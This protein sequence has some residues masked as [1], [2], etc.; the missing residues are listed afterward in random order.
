MMKVIKQRD[1]TEE[2]LHAQGFNQYE[3]KKQ[4]V[5]ARP[6]RRSEAPKRIITSSGEELIAQAGAIICYN[7]GD[8]VRPTL[9]DYDHWP[10]EREIF[11]QTYKA[12]DESDWHPSPPEKHLMGLGCE[13]Y[14]KVAA[15]WA[16]KLD[17]ATYIQS[18][19]HE[20]PELVSGGRYVVIG[21]KG[22]PYSVNNSSFTRRYYQRSRHSIAVFW[23]RI[24]RLFGAT[25]FR[26]EKLMNK[27]HEVMTENPVCC[28]ASDSVGTAARW[29]QTKEIGAVPVVDNYQ[30]KQLIG[31]VTDRD[32]TLR[33]IGAGRDIRNTRIGDVMTPKPVTC[34]P[35]DDLDTALE[36]MARH[37][38][39]RIPVVDHDRQVVGI[40]AQADLATRLHDRRK[41]ADL[42]QE[43][44]QPDS[45]TVRR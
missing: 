12:W 40:I 3:R 8:Q 23:E 24:L 27:C 4:L 16:K 25:A 33:V 32:L 29:M 31:I 10:V 38:V 19:E 45:L 6:L 18:L 22:E 28:L 2:E 17:K 43:V 11:R 14:Y 41:V 36:L 1:W 15:V 7:P 5:M 44:S 21:A 35:S 20:K 9:N 42:L 13:P 39:R 34:H 37:Q 30:T 26:K